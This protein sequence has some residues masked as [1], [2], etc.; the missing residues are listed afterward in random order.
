MVDITA[1]YIS[2]EC[3]HL[4]DFMAFLKEGVD[5]LQNSNYNHIVAIA[6]AD[7]LDELDTNIGFYLALGYWGALAILGAAMC[8]TDQFKLGGRFFQALLGELRRQETR[9]RSY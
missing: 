7:L 2:C 8:G 4:T 1:I 6:S 5:T 3:S 9:R